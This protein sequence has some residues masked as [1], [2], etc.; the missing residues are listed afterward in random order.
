MK[1]TIANLTR[2]F[3]LGNYIDEVLIMTDV[4]SGNEVTDG[5]NE[6]NIYKKTFDHRGGTPYNEYEYDDLDRLAVATYIDDANEVF[7]MD[8]L[9]NRQAVNLR[10]GGTQTY[11]VDDDNNQYTAIDS[12]GLTYDA[13]GN[14][15]TDHHGYQYTYDYENRIVKIEDVNDVN[16]AEFTYDALGRR[17]EVYDARADES[18]YYIYNDQWQ[19]LEEY[20]DTGTFKYCF[21]YGNYID[22]PVMKTG[23]GGTQFY[24]HDHLYSTAALTDSAGDVIERYE[25]DAYGNVHIMD[26]NYNSRSST[27]YDN[28]YTFTGRRLD[29]LDNNRLNIMY[30]RHRYY[31]PQLGRFL[32][33]DPLEYIDGMN[34]YEYV[35]SNPSAYSDPLGLGMGEVLIKCR[36]DYSLRALWNLLRAAADAG[37]SVWDLAE[38]PWDEDRG[39]PN[40]HCVW[41]CR[42]ASRYGKD[43]AEEQA[44]KK[45]ALDMAFKD[46]ADSLSDKCWRKLSDST[47]K[48]LSGW[49][50]SAEQESDYTDNKTGR[51]CSD[52]CDTCEDCCEK[53]GV[54]RGTPEGNKER[55]YSR[56]CVGRY[57]DAMNAGRDDPIIVDPPISGYNRMF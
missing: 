57:A 37:Q 47:K 27:L 43:Y 21:V 56:H 53:N 31:H 22:E 50:C 6:N 15:T 26:G 52:S 39:H 36:G 33:H 9:G 8:D 51:E 18:T 11:T 35:V 1:P 38:R 48:Y 5:A 46:F 41:Q 23:Y 10:S 2:Y 32:Q 7:T 4:D 20:G 28:P 19:V 12:A 42:S 44:D 24:V 30:Y 55:P 25:Y 34:M 45:E 3:I 40:E 49:V 54:G 17:I 13:A 29:A 14:L 16:V